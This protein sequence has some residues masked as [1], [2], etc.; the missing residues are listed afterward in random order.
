[1]FAQVSDGNQVLG[2][3][4]NHYAITDARN[5]CPAG[6]HIPNRTEWDSLFNELG[7]WQV[8][9]LKLKTKNSWGSTIETQGTSSFFAYPSGY[10]TDSGSVLEPS[11]LGYWWV[12]S[13][14]PSAIKM[15]N[16]DDEAFSVSATTGVGYTVRCLK[17]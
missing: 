7:G 8:A 2:K 1:S 16:F 12:K 17:D 9:G 6:W 3:F 4:Y 10:K 15:T 11:N 14:N 13:S 5:L